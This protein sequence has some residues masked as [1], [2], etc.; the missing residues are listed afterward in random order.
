MPSGAPPGNNSTYQSAAY[1]PTTYNN[2]FDNHYYQQEPFSTSRNGYVI[3]MPGVPAPQP[4]NLDS[5]NTYSMHNDPA[6][7][8]NTPPILPA[9]TSHPFL[10]NLIKELISKE[11]QKFQQ[12]HNPYV[13]EKPDEDV[14]KTDQC[15]L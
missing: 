2:T 10:T 14:A 11:N 3:P 7:Y 12:Y 5:Y 13:T 1:C 9:P 6:L 15:P 4:Q 8:S